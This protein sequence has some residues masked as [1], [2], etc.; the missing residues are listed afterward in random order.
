MRLKVLLYDEPASALD[1][2]L[3]GDVLNVI[4]N[5]AK[6]TDM[7]VLTIT[8]KIRFAEKISDRVV[9]FDHGLDAVC[10]AR[11]RGSSRT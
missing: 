8:H 1:P 5:I 3:I 11:Q 2:E 6:S 10:R 9:M 4:R 7:T